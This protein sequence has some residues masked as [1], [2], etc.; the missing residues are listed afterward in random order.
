MNPFDQYEQEYFQRRQQQRSQPM[1]QSGGGMG[2][3]GGLPFG[4][5]AAMAAPPPQVQPNGK[6]KKSFLVDNISTV[7]GIVGGIGG[8]AL[9]AIGGAGI[10]AVPGAAI[11][12]AAGSALG[13]TLENILTGESLGKNVAK[14]AALGGV[15]SAGPVKL[16]KLGLGIPGAVAAR[17]GGQLGAAGVKSLVGGT[18]KEIAEEGGEQ[19]LKT[20]F[21]GRL[22]SMGNEALKSQY[23]TIGK[24]IGR[25]TDPG[26]TIGKLADIGIIKPQDAERVSHAITGADGILTK[27]VAKAIGAAGNVPLDTLPSVL[28]DA[29][30]KNG[31]LG[32]SKGKGLTNQVNAYLEGIKASGGTPESVMSAV[33]SM[34]GQAAD[35]LGKGGNYHLA[36]ATDKQ[37]AKALRQVTDELKDQLYNAA[38]ANKNIA[39]VL[40]PELREQLLQL[41]PK[42]NEWARF[43]NQEVM[44]AKNVGDLRKVQEPFVKIGQIIDE[45]DLNS[46]TF[47]GRMGNWVNGNGSVAGLAAGVGVSLGKN[48][49]A[50]FAG[51]NL[52]DIGTGEIANQNAKGL[53]GT[54]TNLGAIS[55]LTG[56][57]RGQNDDTLEGAMTQQPQGMDFGPEVYPNPDYPVGMNGM[58]GGTDALGLRTMAPQGQMFEDGSMMSGSPYS[59]EAL[60][61]DINRDPQNAKQY[62]AY[63]Q[64]LDEI[65]GAPEMADPMA[66]MS[67][68]SRN[69]IASSDNALNTVTQLEDMFTSAGGASGRLGGRLK[70]VAASAGFDEGAKVYNDLANASV[71]QIAKALAGS[72]AGT[73]SD[74]DAK[75]IINALP[76]FDD[77]P[78]EA[79][80][81]FEAL[82]N[83]LATARQNTML[84]GGGAEELQTPQYGGAF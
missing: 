35:L 64:Q 67:Q 4:P 48:P 69:A 71:T 55:M 9:G 7:G 21:T 81:K 44:T 54:A 28:D 31:L 49:A 60:M 41:R 20:G 56:G 29:V 61:Y 24:N 14:E 66:D 12:G 63:Y 80:A 53:L 18:G 38:G 32:V 84:Y 74:M 5:Q 34:E 47:G 27:Q 57:T 73:V 59:R 2:Y 78:Q 33:R 19:M 26:P 16:V 50:R 10:G 1:P 77:T 76:R 42:S 3:G 43:V 13:E 51:K 46:M 40:T 25:A 70:G 82:K 58:Q 68:S 79:R 36:T 83:R 65:F 72:G 23:G 17:N 62:I 8:G 22:T 30:R 45:A 52:R 75:V 11:G 15:F 37:M 6:K 39:G